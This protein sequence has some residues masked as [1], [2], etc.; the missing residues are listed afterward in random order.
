MGPNKANLKNGLFRIQNTF[1]FMKVLKPTMFTFK[2]TYYEMNDGHG[3]WPWWQR[4]AIA[5]APLKNFIGA[6]VHGGRGR[7]DSSKSIHLRLI[8]RPQNLVSSLCHAVGRTPNN[9]Q[10]SQVPDNLSFWQGL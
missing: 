2:H 10:P 7:G 4:V 1:I 9:E 6:L 5:N 8:Q 3:H